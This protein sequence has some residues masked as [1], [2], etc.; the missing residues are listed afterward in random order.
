MTEEV[1]YLLDLFTQY[2][3]DYV[4]NGHDHMQDEAVFGNTEYLILDALKDDN[5]T[6]GYAVLNV[7]ESEISHEF[8]RFD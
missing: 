4:I 7:S 1:V 3:V 6:A 5:E 2:N 8:V